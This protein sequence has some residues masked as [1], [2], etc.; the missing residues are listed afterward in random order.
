[1]PF[2]A[3]GSS[4]APSWGAGQCSLDPAQ[5]GWRFCSLRPSSLLLFLGLLCAGNLNCLIFALQ[6]GL[7]RME[8][9]E[10]FI[11]PL[12]KG[13]AANEAEQGRVHVVYRRP[14]TSRPPPLG[15]PQALDT[16]KAAAGGR[17]AWWTLNVPPGE[18]R[19]PFCSSGPRPRLRPALADHIAQWACWD[20]GS[21]T[22]A[23]GVCGP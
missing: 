14:P 20:A 7:I 18:P 21:G 8:E 13:L 1:M 10:F 12:E 2:P 4:L 5:P 17:V 16:G 11:E 3:W 23:L 9:E 15:G 19:R 22:S 6:A